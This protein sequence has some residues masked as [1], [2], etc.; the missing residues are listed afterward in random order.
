MHSPGGLL[1][2]G[3]PSF[4]HVPHRPIRQLGVTAFTPPGEGRCC[5]AEQWTGVGKSCGQP[6]VPCGS[7]VDNE[8]QGFGKI[9]ISTACGDPSATSPQPAEQGRRH[10]EGATCGQLRD[11]VRIPRLWTAVSAPVCGEPPRP[12]GIRTQPG[13]GSRGIR[14]ARGRLPLGPH[15]VRRPAGRRRTPGPREAAMSR[16]TS[17]DAA[18]AP[19]RPGRRPPRCLSPAVRRSAAASR[20]VPSPGASAPPGTAPARTRPARTPPAGPRTAKGAR[21][22]V[23][24]AP[25]PRSVRWTPAQPALIRLVSSV[26]WL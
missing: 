3:V 1:P 21:E 16:R 19:P 23:P 25:R 24:C 2:S 7:P 8:D 20:P 22:D 11:N 12:A 15:A 9:G 4:T 10:G 6:R 17:P 13:E 5:V 26:T 18:P 14:G